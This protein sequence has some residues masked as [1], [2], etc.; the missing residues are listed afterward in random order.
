[1][2]QMVMEKT[3]NT[4]AKALTT[5]DKSRLEKVLEALKVN[6]V[7]FPVADIV[8][9]T[10]FKKGHVSNILS[11]KIPMSENF[12]NTIMKHY[13]WEEPAIEVT[14]SEG[15]AFAALIRMEA[16]I[17]AQGAYLS[18]IYGK[19]FDVPATKVLKDLEQMGKDE[20]RKLRDELK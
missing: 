15:K 1:M 11:G 13:K 4:Q 17:L 5:I 19:L 8:K 9:N 10:T 14:E 16:I 6:A 12:F 2:M 18:E 7:R 3:K 20:A